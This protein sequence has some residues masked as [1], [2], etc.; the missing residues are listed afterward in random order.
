[1]TRVRCAIYTRKS[2]EEGLEQSFSS[3]QAQR[4]ACEAFIRSQKSEGWLVL[5]EPY[6]DGGLSGGTLERPALERLLANIDAGQVDLIVVYKVD[7]LTRSLADFAKLVERLE[8]RSVSFVSVTQQFNTSTSMGRLTLNVLLSFA[9]FE[10]EVTGERIRDKIAAS[11][12]K[13]MWMGGFLPLG[14][15]AVA[16]G[17]VINPIEAEAVRSIFQGYLELKSVRLLQEALERQGVK[18]KQRPNCAGRVAGGAS[19]S[20]GALYHLLSNP[21]YLGRIR[22]REKVHPGQ[23]QAILDEETFDRVQKLLAEQRVQRKVRSKS[24]HSS[25]LAGKA[26][27]ETG[28]R[29]IPSH[30]NKGKV[31]YRYYVSQRLIAAK[32]RHGQGWRLPAKEL[33]DAVFEIIR[34]GATFAKLR[35]RA[36][37]SS[38]LTSV[39]VFSAVQKLTVAPG[40]LSVSFDPRPLLPAS[41]PF[42]VPARMTAEAAFGQKRRGI[43]LRLVLEARPAQAPDVTLVRMVH[44]AMNWVDQLRKGVALPSLSASEG[45]Q[46]PFI[47]RRIHLGLLSPKIIAAI[48]DG[49]LPAHLTTQTL[50][51]MDVS[52]NWREQER[53]IL[54]S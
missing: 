42:E 34:S 50:I 39:D 46:K 32:Q 12:A 27:D 36:G 38:E 17:L 26:F 11:K 14:Y 19:F 7:R 54:G 5:P 21:I 31:R 15:D 8:A 23:H 9:Q 45:V 2:S 13:G 25:P 37:G 20:R 49:R 10:R 22:H 1:M 16:E 48:V 40:L 44:R 47:S 41:A 35:A 52:M 29:L 51:D 28:D 6:D 4:E 3:L 33:E 18:S 24:H 43:E 53:Q 30:A